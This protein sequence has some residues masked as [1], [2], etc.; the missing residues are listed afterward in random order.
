VAVQP[1]GSPRP[2]AKQLATAETTATPPA[3]LGGTPLAGRLGPT[4]VYSVA[5]RVL[6]I[7]ILAG[8]GG[9][10]GLSV[11]DSPLSDLLPNGGG[12]PIDRALIAVTTGAVLGFGVGAWLASRFGM[13]SMSVQT[14]ADHTLMAGGVVSLILIMLVLLASAA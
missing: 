13:T 5:V 3:I 11:Q 6:L 14:R 12:D 1:S 8:I 4:S 7:T 9:R 10:L 2:L